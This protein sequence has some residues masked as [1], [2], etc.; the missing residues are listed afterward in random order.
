[1]DTPGHKQNDCAHAERHGFRVADDLA[2]LPV[3]DGELDAV[4]AF[5]MAAF[6]AVMAGE[7]PPKAKD[8]G[9]SDSDQPQTHVDI[10]QANRVRRR[11]R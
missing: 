5:L 8:S 2:D 1:M 3:S 7:T 10:D 9:I 4:E 11:A 6:R